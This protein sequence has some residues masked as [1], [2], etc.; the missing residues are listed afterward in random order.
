MDKLKLPDAIGMSKNADSVALYLFVALFLVSAV[1]ALAAAGLSDRIDSYDVFPLL[2]L[3]FAAI[4]IVSY[5]Y[6]RRW[7]LF[8]IIAVVCVLLYL[9][10][11]TWGYVS[12]FVLVCT[13]GVAVM[14]SI[15]QKRLLGPV[16]TMTERSTVRQKRRPMDRL[17]LFIFGIP[18]NVDTRMMSMDSKVRRGGLPW[19]EL[20]GTM[21]VALVPLLVMWTA[22]FALAAFH[23]NFWQ[24]Y[25]AV[26]T[27]CVYTVM[28][29]IPWVILRTLNVRV[30]TEGGGMS[31]YD[32]LLGTAN[33]MVVPLV[34]M[35]VVVAFSLYTGYE[36]VM[37]I[38]ASAILTAVSI[39]VSSAM[40]Y[41]EYERDV[42]ETVRGSR[43][44]FMPAKNE[45]PGP[46]RLN[47]GIPGTPRRK[48]GS[49]FDQK[50]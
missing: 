35:L 46:H 31:L 40:Y 6:R 9:L 37:Y 7:I 43:D 38:L 29:A 33:R 23:F 32:G 34:L 22:L 2:S 48:E 42:V 12:L 21:R 17:A 45:G 15:L 44:G 1:A 10:S 14:S 16:I 4:G 25:V 19:S 5:I 47:D 36:T 11:P 49:C 41:F 26:F 50:Y 28:G 20:L 39:L 13:R 18:R 30:G 3:P 24:A 8:V 27:V